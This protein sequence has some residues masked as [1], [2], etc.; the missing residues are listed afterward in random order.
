[1]PMLIPIAPEVPEHRFPWRPLV[2]PAVLLIGF[3][4]AY[5]LPFE[6]ISATGPVAQAGREAFVLLQDYA[7]SHVLLCLVPALSC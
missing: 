7:H 1:M 4:A 2:A 5:A 6:D 3:V